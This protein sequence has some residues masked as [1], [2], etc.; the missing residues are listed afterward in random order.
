M[1]A[2]SGGSG[3]LETETGVRSFEFSFGFDAGSSQIDRYESESFSTVDGGEEADDRTIT[4]R[5]KGGQSLGTRGDVRSAFTFSQVR[6]D[7]VL[8]GGGAARYRQRLWGLGIESEW[9][10]GNRDVTRL[11]LGAALDG[12][13]TP[14]SGDKPALDGL[15]DLGFRAGISSLFKTGLSSMPISVVDPASHRSENFIQEH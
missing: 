1:I 11:S 13:D 8:N 4:F 9:R 6:R 3:E 5:A 10:I 12:S 7:E 14:E 15:N 2:L